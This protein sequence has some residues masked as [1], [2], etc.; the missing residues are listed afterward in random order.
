M[1][2]E[3]LSWSQA[4]FVFDLFICGGFGVYVVW[5]LWVSRPPKRGATLGEP[6]I[7]TRRNST[8]AVP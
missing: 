8:Q 7:R 3:H 2:G 4:A 6:D 1:I 5:A